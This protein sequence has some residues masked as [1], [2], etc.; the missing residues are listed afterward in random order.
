MSLIKEHRPSHNYM[1]DEILLP[2]L[3][4]GPREWTKW[5]IF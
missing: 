2:Q 1:A 3:I 4:R 5:V